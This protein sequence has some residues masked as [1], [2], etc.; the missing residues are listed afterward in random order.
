MKRWFI[1]IVVFSLFFVPL[2]AAGENSASSSSSSSAV[3]E[4]GSASS[5]A[6]S[7]SLG[8]NSA[9]AVSDSEAIAES[10]E[11]ET[12]TSSQARKT[13]YIAEKGTVKSPAAVAV[14]TNSTT[15]VSTQDDSI[16]SISDEQYSGLAN[17]L[18]ELEPIG[19]RTIKIL[20]L[21]AATLTGLILVVILQIMIL[22]K[23]R[24]RN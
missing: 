10:S 15:T 9:T 20:N 6:N 21:L 1:G 5:S 11:S 12:S 16:C 13:T 2:A 19:E 18:E 22:L 7:S 4:T 17:Q 8:D 24:R 14:A 23:S 3:A